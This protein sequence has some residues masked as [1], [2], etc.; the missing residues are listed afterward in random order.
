MAGG[1]PDE[2]R[3]T[4][5]EHLDVLR[6]SLLRIVAVTVVFAVAAFV[7][8]EQLFSVVLAPGSSDFVTY[9][10]FDRVGA[11][12]GTPPMEHFTVELINTEL[13]A[14]FV[15]HMKTALFAGLL[16][17]SPYTVFLLFR[18]VTPALYENERKYSVGIASS[19][20]V[21]F[22]LGVLLNYFLIFPLT[23]RFLGMYQVSATVGN[24]ITLQSYMD[25]LLT[26]SLTMG[27]VFEVPVLCW[28]L[29]CAGLLEAA[30]MRRYRKYA[31]VVILVAAAI[32]TP[33]SDAFTM[34][35]VALPIWLLY[36]LSILIVRLTN[37]RKQ[38]KA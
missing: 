1:K 20:Y 9:R 33:T 35:L 32:I 4:F 21:M 2:A 7:C 28:L 25:T 5:W 3:M 30:F 26:M 38:A 24:Y 27:I 36:E 29:A 16:L 34:I 10:L 12:L 13:A 17:S 18:F 15:L 19:A 6:A 23:V 22:I 31:V 11:W 14:Q 37:R 8:K